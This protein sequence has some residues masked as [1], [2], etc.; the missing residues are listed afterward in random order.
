MAEKKKEVKKELTERVY[1][2]PLRKKTVKTVKYKRS[3]KAIKLIREFLK[4][5]MKSD[6]VIID[7]KVNEKVWARGIKSPPGKVK[8]KAV[9]DSTGKVIATLEE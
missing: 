3:P 6:N 4:K 9:K 5:H 2:I 8:V 7:K 1:T